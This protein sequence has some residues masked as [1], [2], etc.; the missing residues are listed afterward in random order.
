MQKGVNYFCVYAWLPTNMPARY[1]PPPARPAACYY[2]EKNL[3]KEIRQ[4]HWRSN[5]NNLI[6]IISI[7]VQF[8]TNKVIGETGASC[9]RG[10]LLQ[11]RFM[12]NYQIDGENADSSCIRIHQGNYWRKK[13]V[14]AR[15]LFEIWTKITFY[16]PETFLR[17]FTTFLLVK[18]I[19]KNGL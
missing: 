13:T 12:Q 4:V 10:R 17:I 9:Y 1:S 6:S 2:L 16:T 19:S 18:S 14:D 3:E 15:E 7:N 5:A 11:G 8:D